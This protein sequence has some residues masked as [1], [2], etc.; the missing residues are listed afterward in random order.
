MN[1][2]DVL[3]VAPGSSA[4]AIRA[5]YLDLA[6]RHHPD[7]HGGDDHAGRTEAERRMRAVNEAWA[8]LSDEAK[9]FDYDV[10]QGNVADPTAFRPLEPDEPD[11]VDPRDEPDLPYRPVARGEQRQTAV[12]TLLPIV[13]LAGSVG[14][15][16]LWL[17][18]AAPALLALAVAVFL[19]ACAGFVVAPLL[20]L[21]RATRDEG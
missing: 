17:V 18:V 7:H 2:Y 20:A 1:H 16:A 4:A 12:A 13:A 5:A 15:F 11:D 19:L 6:R 3:G 14:L 8:V 10:G 9:R 21:S